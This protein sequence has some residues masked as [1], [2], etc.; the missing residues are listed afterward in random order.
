[1]ERS[2]KL[3]GDQ[4][5]R[6]KMKVSSLVN[7]TE[8]ECSSK[9][10]ILTLPLYAALPQQRQNRIFLP[11][12]YNTRKIVLAT[13]IAETSITIPGIKFVV[14]SGVAKEK[15][16]IMQNRKGTGQYNFEFVCTWGKAHANIGMDVLLIKPVSKSSARQRA[17]RA[18]REVWF[19]HSYVSKI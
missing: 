11:T 6:G 3:Y 5:P 15:S 12:P 14:D 19:S 17:G 1:M 4:I 7:H 16:F 18:G 9:V 2:I 13:N 10:Q 8:A